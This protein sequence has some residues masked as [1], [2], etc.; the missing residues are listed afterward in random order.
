MNE[1]NKIL[2][3]ILTISTSK[4][5]VLPKH[6]AVELPEY[7]WLIKEDGKITI[8]PAEVS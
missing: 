1:R 4:V 7:V 6:W 2:R 5:V 8:Q 3:K